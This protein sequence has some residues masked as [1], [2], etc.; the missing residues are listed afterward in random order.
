MPGGDH[1]RF[2]ND[3]FPLTNFMT[4]VALSVNYAVRR[5]P[6]TEIVMAGL[7]GG[8]WTTVL[9][10]AMDTRITKSVPVAGSWPEYLRYAPTA[11]AATNGDYEQH[12]PGLTP[13]YLDLYALAASNQRQQLQVFNSDDPCCYAGSAPVD[14]LGRLQ[15]AATALGG[16]FDMTI[17]QNAV[18]SVHSSVFDDIAGAPPPFVPV[19]AEWNLDESDG[20]VLTDAGG[21]YHGTFVNGP[22][23][24]AAGLT[25]DGGTAVSFDGSSDYATVPDSPKLRPGS[26]EYAIEIWA[27]FDSTN[28]G[29]AFGKF[30][31]A[32]P[33][34]GPTVF[35]NLSGTTPTPG[36]VQIRDKRVSGYWLDSAAT[37]LND[38][39][40]RAYV[41]QRRET[42]PG[43]W[44][45]QIFINGVLNAERMLPSVEPL[46]ASGPIYLFSRPDAGQYVR[47]TYDKVRYHVGESLSAE[48]VL[49]N[50]NA[51]KPY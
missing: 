44:K 2:A 41:F 1:S 11:N 14:Y 37:G 23:L 50:Y 42:S 29:M 18:H 47:G 36:R 35:F 17:V 48:T 3:A 38:G 5:K 33:Y 7:S 30:E 40:P 49:A 27:A 31:A 8:G 39:V 16:Q 25:N 15:T 6:Y 24:G 34:A 46:Y 45:L 9:Y 10:S 20:A 32:D 22:T 43:V 4:P 21:T 12:L 19:T 28:Y 51:Q 26:M 13:S